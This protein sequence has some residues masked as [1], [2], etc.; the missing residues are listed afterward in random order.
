MIIIE[1][2]IH[3]S[4]NSRRIMRNAKTGAP[5]VAKSRSSKADEE[6]FA[7]QLAVQREE[8][9]RMV[10]GCAYPLRIVFHFR[11]ATSRQFDYVNMAQGILDAMVKAEYIPDDCADYVLPGFLPYELDKNAGCDV[12]IETD[13]KA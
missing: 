3:S 13:G 6:S 9:E 11:R 1:G 2:E 8:W 4:K 12:S 7:L 5:F 10:S